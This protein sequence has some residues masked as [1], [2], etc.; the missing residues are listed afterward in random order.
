MLRDL[1]AYFVTLGV[2]DQASL[3]TWAA[4]AAEAVAPPP[5]VAPADRPLTVA[6]LGLAEGLVTFVDDD[7]G[8]IQWVRDHPDGFV[9]NSYRR[10][11]ANYLVLHRA[12][13]YSINP[14]WRPGDARSWTVAY[15]R[16]AP[17]RPTNSSAGHEP[18]WPTHGLRSVQSHGMTRSP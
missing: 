2:T 3:K 12:R 10:P 16:P 9:L 18:D 8:Y 15:R 6:P 5:E 4:S 14:A 7:P 1:V 13:C 11:T 17:I